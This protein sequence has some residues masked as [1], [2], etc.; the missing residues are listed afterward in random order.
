V[1]CFA[2]VKPVSG[3]PPGLSLTVADD[4]K[5]R[6]G[7][8]GARLLPIRIPPTLSGYLNAAVILFGP[9]LAA[10]IMTA[11]IEGKAGVR[12]LLSRLVLWRVG[13][14]WYLFVPRVDHGAEQ[15]DQRDAIRTAHELNNAHSICATFSK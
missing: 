10:L 5:G 12:R 15:H 14:Q 2:G 8:D 13:I 3:Q 6:L 9:T 4:G 1:V 11:A 7:K